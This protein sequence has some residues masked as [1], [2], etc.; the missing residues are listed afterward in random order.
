MKLINNKNEGQ[1]QFFDEVLEV[2]PGPIRR[3]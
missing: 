3:R 1:T 2:L